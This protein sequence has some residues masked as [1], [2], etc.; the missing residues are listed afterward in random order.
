MSVIMTLRAKGN[1]D[2]LERLAAEKAD[3]LRSL[4]DRAKEH[5]AIA[6]RF[7]GSD[8]G[9]IMVVDEWPDPQSFQ[10]FYASAQDEIDPMMREVGVTAEPEVIFWRKLETGDEIGWES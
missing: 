1:P 9:W 3:T 4:A 2:E 10:Q 8:D 6:H 5:G 7:Y